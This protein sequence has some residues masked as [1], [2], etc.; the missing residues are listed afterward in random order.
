MRPAAPAAFHATA[1]PDESRV[2]WVDYAKGVCIILVVMMHSTLG[3]GEAMG[4]EGVLHAVVAFSRPFRMP[5][6]FLVSGLFLGRVIDRDW[7]TYLD[8]KVVHFA[9]FYALWVLIQTVFKAPPLVLAGDWAGLRPFLLAPVEPFG[10]LWFIYLLPIFFVVTRLLRP[11][12]PALVLALGVVLETARIQA[13][14]TVVDEFASRWVYFLA[15]TFLAGRVFAFADA[16]GARPRLALAG[17]AAWAA[18]EAVAVFATGPV[19]GAPNLAAAPLFS[20]AFGFAG[21]LAVVAV[22][23]L[24]ARSG[25]ARIV[26]TCGRNSLP[27]YLSFFLPM[28]VSRALLLQ[29][30]LV[31]DVGVVSVLVTLCG[32]AVP[33]AFAALV[34]GTRFAWLFERPAA[35]HFRAPARAGLAAQVGR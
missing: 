23:A 11:A 3:V 2:A 19:L 22:A 31:A 9:Y 4:G 16:V 17:L 24:L 20:L 33:L 21:A 26:R 15:G 5:D 25:A 18:V 27:I 28:A 30:G 10:T 35:F 7:R 6:F 29:T 14:W 1:L 32:V 12:S 8:R 13:G 34:R